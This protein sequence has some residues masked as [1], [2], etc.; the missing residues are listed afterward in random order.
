MK[1]GWYSNNDFWE[2][3]APRL[4]PPTKIEAAHDEVGSLIQLLDLTPGA[5]ILDMCCGIG[6]HSVEFARLGYSVV[7]VDRLESFLEQAK[8]AAQRAEV[9]VDWVLDDI[10][11]FED[12]DSFDL[13]LSMFTS[14]GYFEE[15]Q[16]N[17]QVLVNLRKSLRDRGRLVIETIGKETLARI[18]QERDWEV[19]G[20]VIFAQE[21][22]VVADWKKMENR[23]LSFGPDHQ[24]EHRVTH[25][26]YSAAELEGM[27]HSAG[28]SSVKFF[29]GFDG[30]PYD[31]QAARMIAVAVK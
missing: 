2:T 23:F 30:R 19:R 11:S 12:P 29:G 25:W 18:F 5:R 26:I 3:A 27:L 1:D 14:F 7:G 28:F 6:R 22:R 24:K 16:D 17:L 21:R 4:F 10:R 8:A 15:H 13:I 31:H 20:G 9:T